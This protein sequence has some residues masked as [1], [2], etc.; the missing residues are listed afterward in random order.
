MPNITETVLD[1]FKRLQ[2]VMERTRR[3][4]LGE[5]EK[6]AFLMCDTVMTGKTVFACGNGGSAATAQHFTAELMGRYVEERGPLP[7]FSLHT[8]TSLITAVGNDY[9]FE[10][11]FARQIDAVGKEGDLLVALTTSGASK[12]VLYAIAAAH[13]KQMNVIVL[14]GAK[15]AQLRRTPG[16]MACVSVPD[17]EIARIQEVHD[18]IIH[19]W[20]EYIDARMKERIGG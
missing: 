12:N 14:T 8:D 17:K 1:A 4:C 10:Q 18:L 13:A 15:G 11:V 19:I 5:I 16:V 7:A 6:S 3:Q 2:D 9:G 20:C